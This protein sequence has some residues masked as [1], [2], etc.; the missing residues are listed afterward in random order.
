MHAAFFSSDFS[1]FFLPKTV[2]SKGKE[3]AKKV[4]RRPP[5]RDEIFFPVVADCGLGGW[6]GISAAC[7]TPPPAP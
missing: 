3:F 7:A 1:F 5:V 6:S 4:V 2:E